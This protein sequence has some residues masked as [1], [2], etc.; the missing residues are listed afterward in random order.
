MSKVTSGELL[1][2][3]KQMAEADI[4]RN[5]QGEIDFAL[6]QLEKDSLAKAIEAIADLAKTEAGLALAAQDHAD[7]MKI[8]EQQV[9]MQATST[10]PGHGN[11]S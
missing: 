10:G 11:Y 5:E 2:F 6:L 7:H 3:V 8:H 4:T 1:E 9:L